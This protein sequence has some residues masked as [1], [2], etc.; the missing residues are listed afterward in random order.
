MSLSQE[1]RDSIR[2]TSQLFQLKRFV[3]VIL[4][5]FRAARF[6]GNR[7][8]SYDAYWEKRQLSD[9]QPRYPIMAGLIG[10]GAS[11]LDYGC[12]DGG[13]LTY[14]AGWKRVAA[15]GADISE[16]AVEKARA[17][18]VDARVLCLDD[19]MLE[20]SGSGRKFDFVVFSEVIEH[21]ADSEHYLKSLFSLTDDALIVTF[22]NIAFYPHRIRLALAGKAPVQW[23]Q[24]P[25]EHLRFWSIPDFGQWVRFVLNPDE[26]ES[27]R[28]YPSNGFEFIGLHKAWPNL[29]ANQI[30]TVI[31]RKKCHEEE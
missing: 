10:E 31:R 18:G 2:S 5:Q 30:V 21:V 25:G 12:G 8:L 9:I 19:L 11:V 17:R 22:P 4:K 28:F 1:N 20:C 13:F 29:F 26:I 24:H 15:T 3:H 6:S 23:V 7:E 16:V 27:V 14:L